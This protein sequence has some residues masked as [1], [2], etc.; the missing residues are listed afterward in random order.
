MK[1]RKIKKRRKG[2][3][4]REKERMQKRRNIEKEW[5]RERNIIM[6][7]QRYTKLGRR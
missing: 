5:Y 4:E 3:R 1:S 6:E 7:G 2:E